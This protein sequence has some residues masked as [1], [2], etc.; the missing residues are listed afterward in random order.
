MPL[1]AKGHRCANNREFF[2]AP[3]DAVVAVM[4]RVRDTAPRL[5][6]SEFGSEP[7]AVAEAPI[8]DISEALM[9]E[10]D[11]LFRAAAE[12]CIQY[13]QGSTALMQRRLRIGYGRAARIIDQLHEAGVLG[14][15]D[16][17][18]PRAVLVGLEK[19]DRICRGPMTEGEP[20]PP[21]AKKPGWFERLLRSGDTPLKGRRR[22]P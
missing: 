16:G 2:S 6:V 18:H 15:P 21:P 19:L 1:T 12:V 4:E 9:E 3:V 11:P 13:E 17:A 10:R 8:E 14:P 7:S 5:A 22:R 20:M